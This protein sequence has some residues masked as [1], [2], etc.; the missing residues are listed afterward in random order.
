LLAGKLTFYLFFLWGKFPS[1]LTR[2]IELISMFFSMKNTIDVKRMQFAIF[3]FLFKVGEKNPAQCF[4][5]D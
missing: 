3:S 1:E 2:G 5:L 4:P